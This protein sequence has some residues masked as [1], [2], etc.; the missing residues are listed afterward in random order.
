MTARAALLPKAPIY[1]IGRY[2]I[3]SDHF[4]FEFGWPEFDRDTAWAQSRLAQTGVAAGDMVLI[5]A[6][7][8]ESPWIAPVVRALK[9]LRAIYMTAEV[10]QFDAVRSAAFLQ[11]FPV[12]AVVGLGA[13]TLDGWAE[14]QLSAHDLLAA[15]QIIWA[16]PQAINR[17]ADM[18]SRVAPL[19]M[20]GPALAI[21]LPGQPGASLNA[22]E[23]RVVS[24]D[25]L[26]EISSVA[27]RASSFDRAPTGLHGKVTESDAGI[28]SVEVVEPFR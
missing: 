8:W 21:G 10:F 16:R 23:W 7:P 12:K 6:A 19:I 5:T 26:L 15:V 4:D 2:E 27:D 18:S 20:V 14:K 24:Q 13:E 28:L 22:K 11:Q 1:G 17:L 3:G 9:N 25:G